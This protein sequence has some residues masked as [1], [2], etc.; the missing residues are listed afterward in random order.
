MLYRRTAPDAPG[1]CNGAVES[2]VTR[3]DIVLN[4]AC[5]AC[6]AL[7]LGVVVMS[8]VV[9]AATFPTVKALDPVVPQFAGYPGGHWR[10]VGG[11]VA[12]SVFR[13][14]GVLTGLLAAGSG[15]LAMWMW[16]RRDGRRSW[17]L[18]TVPLAIG[19]ACVAWNLTVLAPRMEGNLTRFRELAR[20]GNVAG[21]D[22]ARDAF[23]R[24]HPTASRLLV[25]QAAAVA[26]ALAACVL[27]VP[28]FTDPRDG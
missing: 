23:N 20:E 16:T 11:A 2:A 10:L 8:G 15:G 19:A 17:W 1:V 14:A 7:W 27:A 22:A 28:R 12:N 26:A 9:A 4:T 21:A 5:A 3:R 13:I 6:L 24:D 25:V 18:R